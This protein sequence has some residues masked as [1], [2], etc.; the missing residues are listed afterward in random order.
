MMVRCESVSVSI[1]GIG[2]AVERSLSM[3]EAACSTHAFSTTFCLRWGHRRAGESLRGG[4]RVF[5]EESSFFY[6]LTHVNMRRLQ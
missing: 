1:G 2:S 6:L 5:P 4:A 3:G